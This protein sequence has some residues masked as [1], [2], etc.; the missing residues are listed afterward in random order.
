MLTNKS[1]KK[2]VKTFLLSFLVVDLN[3][4]LKKHL[5]IVDLCSELNCSVVGICETWHLPEHSSSLIEVRGF[6][7]IRNDSTSGRRKH[8]VCI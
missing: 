4:I 1:N 2:L 7:L 8:G 5:Y 3:S 6:T